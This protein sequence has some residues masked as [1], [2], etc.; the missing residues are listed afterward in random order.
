MH[1]DMQLAHFKGIVS[2]DEYFLRIYNN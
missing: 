2:R 1:D